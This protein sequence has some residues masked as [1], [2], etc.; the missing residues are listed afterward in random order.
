MIRASIVMWLHFGQSD[1]QNAL[2]VRSLTTGGSTILSVTGKYRFGAV[3]GVASTTLVRNTGQ[4]RPPV[5][6]SQ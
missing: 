4:F 3:M 5:G 6:E 1:L 2:M